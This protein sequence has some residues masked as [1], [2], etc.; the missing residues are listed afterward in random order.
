MFGSAF[1][2]RIH[3]FVR[4]LIYDMESVNPAT[5]QPNVNLD[6][7]D[8]EF[9]RIISSVGPGPNIQNRYRQA[10]ADYRTL[11]VEMFP[12]EAAA[13]AASEAARQPGGGRNKKTA[14]RA[15]RNKKTIKR[16]KKTIKRN[17][18]PIKR[19]KKPIKRSKRKN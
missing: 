8:N 5:L 9:I 1:E 18:K 17:K 6:P 12:T 11:C 7:N 4:D 16:N 19:S 2:K 10:I 14:K 15:K 3:S 13:Q